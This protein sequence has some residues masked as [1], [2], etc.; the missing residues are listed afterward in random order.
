MCRHAIA[1]NNVKGLTYIKERKAQVQEDKNVVTTCVYAKQSKVV[2]ELNQI[3]YNLKYRRLTNSYN[4]Q[5]NERHSKLSN[6][7]VKD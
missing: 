7:F 3:K 2:N 6:P 4:F 5:H 1:L